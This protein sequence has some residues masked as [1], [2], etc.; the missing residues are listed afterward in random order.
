MDVLVTGGT[1]FVG[2]AVVRELSRS[3]HRVRLLARPP[4]REA[5]REFA[6]RH[7]A[8]VVVG[9]VLEPATLAAAC[10]GVAAVVHLVGIIS[11]V[12]RNTFANAH[13][14]ATENV[15]RAAQTAG[16]RR[17]LQ[18]SALGTRPAAVSRYHQTKWAAE[19]RVRGSGLEWT[20]LRPSLIYGPEDHFVNLFAAISRWS[21]VMPVMGSGRGLLQPVAVEVVAA[22]FGR[23]LTEP[24]TV[25]RVLEVCGRERLSLVQLLT[26][27]LTVLRRRRLLL[28]IPLAVARWQATVLEWVY[29]KLLGRAAPFNRD[30]LLMLQEDNVGDPQPIIDLLAIQPGSFR[31]GI[32]RWLAPPGG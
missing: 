5:V 25:G 24:P 10:A 21:P 28:L 29:P 26:T 16:V 31:D 7:G 22:C 27:L 2:H 30:Q 1:G 19:E 8:T 11:E 3:G 14:Q 32:A 6:A 15:L 23:A 17:Y 9:D 18:M 12:G 13:I 4:G 20:I